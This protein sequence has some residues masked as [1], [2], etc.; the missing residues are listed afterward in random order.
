MNLVQSFFDYRLFIVNTI[1]FALLYIVLTYSN[2][3]FLSFLMYSTAILISNYFCLHQKSYIASQY[4]W[5]LFY[6][7]FVLNPSLSLLVHIN[8]FSF[9]Y[10]HYG[11]ITMLS[12]GLVSGFFGK[13]FYKK[14]ITSKSFAFSKNTQLLVISFLLIIFIIIVLNFYYQISFRGLDTATIFHPILVNFMNLC[15]NFFIPALIAF[16]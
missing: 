7:G 4:M 15:L 1:S 5:L 10:I 8:H 3:E 2:I 9:G 12:L 14:D 16:S 6:G 13:I 11:T